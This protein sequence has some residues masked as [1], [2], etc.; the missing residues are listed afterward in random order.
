MVSTIYIY[1]LVV[2]KVINLQGHLIDSYF[3]YMHTLTINWSLY[4]LYRAIFMVNFIYRDFCLFVR[5]NIPI[6]IPEQKRCFKNIRQC[7]SVQFPHQ[8]SVFHLHFTK[9]R[10]QLS[11]ILYLIKV[12]TTQSWYVISSDFYL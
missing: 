11:F 7:L 8:L 9:F 10:C 5:F 4:I 1:N 6:R 3:P 2:N 12:C